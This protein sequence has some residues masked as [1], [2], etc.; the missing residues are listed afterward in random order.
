M[1]DPLSTY[2]HDHLAGSH[3]AIQLLESLRDQYPDNEPGTLAAALLAEISEDQNTLQ[4]IVDRVGRSP[5]DLTQAAGWF[6]EKASQFKLHRDHTGIGIGTFEALE[7]LM[8]GISG[9]LALW[10]ALPIIREADSRI[11]E[12]DFEKLATRARDQFARVEEQR[13]RTARYTF[14]PQAAPVEVHH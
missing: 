13:L 1:A 6:A 2:L 12:Q 5:V 9:K 10:R 8:L 14:L 4:E 3:F 7:A 11:P